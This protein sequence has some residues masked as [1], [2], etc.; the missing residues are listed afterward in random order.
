MRYTNPRTHS[1]THSR[2]TKKALRRPSGG[3]CGGVVSGVRG[4][5]ARQ[6][7]QHSS[8]SRSIGTPHHH[9]SRLAITRSAHIGGTALYSE[10]GDAM[11]TSAPHGCKPVGG[12]GGRRPCFLRH[13]RLEIELRAAARN[14]D[15]LA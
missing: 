15:D 8:S 7:Q 1:L 13:T 3:V 4:A 14:N 9:S 5:A 11:R 2:P 10:A 6:T 12:G